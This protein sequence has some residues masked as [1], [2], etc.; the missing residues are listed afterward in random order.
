M[1]L[2]SKKSW[3]CDTAI[4]NLFPGIEHP[5]VEDLKAVWGEVVDEIINE[6]MAL[7]EASQ[8]VLHVNVREEMALELAQLQLWVA[9]R[10]VERRVGGRDLLSI[11]PDLERE[12]CFGLEGAKLNRGTARLVYER[13][14]SRRLEERWKPKSAKAMEREASPKRT[15]LAVKPVDKNHFISRWFIRDYWATNDRIFRWRRRDGGW[16]SNS[17]G[18]GQWGYR[19]NLYSDQLEAYFGLLEGDAHRPVEM[20][21]ATHPLNEPQRQSLVGFL[22][23]HLLRNPYLMQALKRALTPVIDELGRAD[24][25]ERPRRAY[26]SLYRNN[27]LYHQVATPILWSPWA[28]VRS[29]QPVFV[30]PDTFAA[31]TSPP[32]GMR[33]IAPLTPTA[34]FVTL[35]GREWEKRIVPQ[36][37]RADADLARRISRALV[38]AAVDEFLSHLEFEP[39]GDEAEPLSDV[40]E[41]IAGAIDDA[42]EGVDSS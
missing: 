33:L 31:R 26:E 3:V 22:V 38:E 40:L 16:T 6:M 14:W 20:L 8:V 11:D 18:S 41:E 9:D 1:T 4:S 42:D 10:V 19:H 27:E 37:V 5:A 35:P 17:L 21:L 30:L 39:C 15:R 28:I 7:H 32:G 34:C 13:I 12:E 36:S 23:I 2:P 29:E 24:N 25:T